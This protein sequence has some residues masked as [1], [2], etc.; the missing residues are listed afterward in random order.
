MEISRKEEEEK[1]PQCLDVE[2]WFLDNLSY[3]LLMNFSYHNSRQFES[4][5]L[6]LHLLN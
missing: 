4:L 1:I 3:L 2:S 5:G 6:L